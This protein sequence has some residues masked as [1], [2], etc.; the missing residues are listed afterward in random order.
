MTPYLTNRIADQ[1]PAERARRSINGAPFRV[2]VRQRATF[3]HLE[4]NGTPA[5]DESLRMFA[6]AELT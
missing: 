3:E 2:A 5:E 1:P 4:A 6:G